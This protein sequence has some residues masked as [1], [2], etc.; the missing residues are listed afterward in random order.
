MS[1]GLQYSKE[2]IVEALKIYEDVGFNMNEFMKIT[3]RAYNPRSIYYWSY[4]YGQDIFTSSEWEN[5]RQRIMA[6]WEQSQGTF[7]E[8]A[9]EV[10]QMALERLEEIIPEEK[11]IDR[12]VN[13]IKTLNDVNGNSTGSGDS[14]R[15]VLQLIQN[16]TFKNGEK[17]D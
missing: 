16:A 14:G 6:K 4:K 17:K 2:E 11:N 3:E 10:K 9:A 13:V 8:R 1:K 15:N 5:S 7:I 12:L